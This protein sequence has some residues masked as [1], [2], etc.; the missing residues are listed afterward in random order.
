MP[1]LR[2]RRED[3]PLLVNELITRIEHERVGSVRFTPAALL[4][5]TDHGWPG[6]V[7]ELANLVERMCILQPNGL[8]DVEQLPEKFRLGRPGALAAAE[9]VLPQDAQTIEP[10]L[11]FEGLDLKE[12]LN[13]IE[14]TLIQRALDESNGVVAQAAK[15]LNL[16]RTTLVEKMRKY[17]MNAAES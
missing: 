13:R 12:H 17:Q 15:R 4:C 7:R 1:P 8:V 2:E 3:V 11:P 14:S 6:N 10:R 16:G 5:L 9:A